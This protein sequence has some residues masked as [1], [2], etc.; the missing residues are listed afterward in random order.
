LSGAPRVRL[1]FQFTHFAALDGVRG[2]AILLVLMS[3]ARF[4]T[5]HLGGGFLG[6]DLFFV[7]SGFLITGLA[8]QEWSGRGGFSFKLFYVRRTLRLVPALLA[9]LLVVAAYAVLL[10][11]HSARDA[12]LEWVIAGATYTTNLAITVQPGGTWPASLVDHTWSLGVEE[13]FYLLWPIAL[14]LLVLRRGTRPELAT[15]GLILAIVGFAVSRGVTYATGARL[16]AFVRPDTRLD[17]LLVGCLAALALY[18][19]LFSERTRGRRVVSVTWTLAALVVVLS[20]MSFAGQSGDEVDYG[21]LPFRFLFE[22][23]ATILAIAVALLLVHMV[24][25]PASL[26]ARLIGVAPLRW[27]GL[28]SYGTYIWHAS[29]LGMLEAGGRR[30][31]GL[32]ALALALVLGTVSYFTIERPFL[33]LKSQFLAGPR[34]EPD[35]GAL[36]G[37]AQLG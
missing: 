17:E 21:A 31:P 13:Q 16:A 34:L 19:G 18:W 37:S 1:P 33:R 28:I 29:I 36:V 7:L 26:L 15:A 4:G 2:I 30:L 14:V 27:L 3:H 6:V 23:G 20:I 12:Q 8:L 22:G 9:M 5:W 10:E 25:E 24:I 32:A 35:A 11:P